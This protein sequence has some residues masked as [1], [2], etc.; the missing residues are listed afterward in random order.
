M[1]SPIHTCSAAQRQTQILYGLFRLI[2]SFQ[3]ITDS[4]IYLTKQSLRLH[5]EEPFVLLDDT[6]TGKT[7][8]SLGQL[9]DSPLDATWFAEQVV[10]HV[11]YDYDDHYD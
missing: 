9:R 6:E 10:F 1:R 4:K 8:S 3:S 2:S 11:N 5:Y 7:T